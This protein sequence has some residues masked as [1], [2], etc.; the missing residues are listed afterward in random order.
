ME[1]QTMDTAATVPLQFLVS[2]WGIPADMLI[3]QLGA[4]RILTDELE[5]RHVRVSDAKALLQKRHA[6]KAAAREHHE[7]WEAQMVAMGDQVRARANALLANKPDHDGMSAY[8]AM[9]SVDHDT[10]LDAAG[11]R[12]DELIDAERR[13][14]VGVYHPINPQKG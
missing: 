12:Y 6:D 2:D 13:G 9:A 5:I 3:G 7:Q 10:R 14:N 4:E 8:E 11:R 1:N